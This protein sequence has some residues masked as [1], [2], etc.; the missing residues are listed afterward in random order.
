MNPIRGIRYKC[1]LRYDYD[2]CEQ[3]EENIGDHSF[4]MIKIRDNHYEIKFHHFYPQN[5]DEDY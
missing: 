5:D 4:P 3:C 1:S 2:L